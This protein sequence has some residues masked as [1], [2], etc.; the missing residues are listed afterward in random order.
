MTGSCWNTCEKC[1]AGYNAP[2][3]HKCKPVTKQTMTLEE[4]KKWMKSHSCIDVDMDRYDE[5]GNHEETKIY[6]VGDKLFGVELFNGE[7]CYTKDD[8][9]PR[10]VIEK[11]YTATY[12]EFVCV[13]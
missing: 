11:T 3:G 5:C 8:Y 2:L 6:Q 7:P 9:Q 1:G 13:G 10:E 4:L 12:Y